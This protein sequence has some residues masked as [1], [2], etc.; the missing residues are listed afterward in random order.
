MVPPPSPP[1][2]SQATGA[3]ACFFP[4]PST[5][6]RRLPCQVSRVRAHCQSQRI[7]T[8]PGKAGT[9][10]LRVAHPAVIAVAAHTSPTDGARNCCA[11]CSPNSTC[12]QWFASY[13]PVHARRPAH[14]R[15]RSSPPPPR[16]PLSTF[17]FLPLPPP[18][19][20]TLRPILPA[21]ARIPCNMA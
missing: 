16:H 21:R 15:S 11:F 20:P 13:P 14:C 19:T 17:P 1:P 6:P 18:L 12:P 8:S 9:Y 10:P 4:L 5:N 2:Q 7:A 3:G